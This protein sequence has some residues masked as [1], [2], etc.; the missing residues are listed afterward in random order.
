MSSTSIDMRLYSQHLYRDILPEESGLE[1]GFMEVGFI[2]LAT[3]PDQ[4]H[5]LRRVAA[6]NRFHGIDVTELTPP[7]VQERFPL[8]NSNTNIIAG[9]HCPTDGRVNPTD[10]TMALAKAARRTGNV[11][12]LEGVTVKSIMTSVDDDEYDGNQHSRTAIGVRVQ[13]PSNSNS[14]LEIPANAVVNCAGIWARQ[15]GETA[16]VTIPNQAAEHYYMITEDIPN[17]DPHLPV[18]EDMSRYC[19]MRPEGKGL[20]IGF[21]EPDGKSW[22][23]DQDIPNHFSFGELDPDWDRMAPHLEKSMELLDPSIR[24]TV[25]IK[26]LFCGPESF[27]PDGGPIIGEAP[28]L[29]H[30][31][32]AAGMNSVGILSGGGVGKVLAK[33]IAEGVTPYDVDVTGIMPDRFH[34][35]QANPEYRKERTPEVLADTYRLHYPD[36]QQQTC[37][38]AKKSPFHDRLAEQ[39]AVFKDVSGWESP[40]W[41]APQGVEPK[42]LSETFGRPHWFDHW[43]AEHKAC[44]ENV[45]LFDMSFMSKFVVQ[46]HDAANFLNYLSTANIDGPPGKI[47]YTQWLDE[48]GFLQADLTVTKL[49]ER[50]FLVVATDTMHNK[51]LAHMRHRLQKAAHVFVTDVT[52]A[53]AQLNL[54]G[55][56]SRELLNS[57]TSRDMVRV[58]IFCIE[59]KICVDADTVF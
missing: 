2:E 53:Y 17:M 15:L 8:L 16:G 33:W 52:G 10:V 30:Y 48:E 21:F 45:A 13:D 37:R 24:E 54:Q 12:I 34:R 50:T 22:N 47:T 1:T 49:T 18:I 20:L 9:F 25:G 19:Y 44:R 46:G 59:E 35:Y 58:I 4:L 42:I 40:T 27:S 36:H 38:G 14:V 28:E 11:Q 51:V 32:I 39:N 57:I 7:Q 29:R 55:P 41:Y 3:S 5:Y 31:Y 43:A 26:K 23:V 6:L 56:R